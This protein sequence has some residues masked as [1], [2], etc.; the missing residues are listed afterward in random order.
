MGHL[1]SNALQLKKTPPIGGAHFPLSDKGNET[2][3]AVPK[4][5]Q[6]QYQNLP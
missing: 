4:R 6:A 3:K 1:L 2:V 5:P